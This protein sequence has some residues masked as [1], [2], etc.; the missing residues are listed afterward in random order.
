MIKKTI[1]VVDDEPSLRFVYEKTFAAAGYEVQTAGNAAMALE[2]MRQT[3]AA[4][5][6]LDLNL[7]GMN[8]LE[9]CQEVRKGWPWS[10]V[11]A[12][13][14]YAS[15]FELVRCR[16]VGFEDYFIKPVASKELLAAAERAFQK[17][18]RWKRRSPA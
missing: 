16:E 11:I 5:L 14:G 12:V 17:L 6:F 15:L 7:P 8:G 18:D 4:I 2:I 1:L 9:L 3:P 13:T 10:I